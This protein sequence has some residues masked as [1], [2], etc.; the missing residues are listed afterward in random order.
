MLLFVIN[1]IAGGVIVGIAG[2][3]SDGLLG[4]WLAGA[5]ANA[6]IT[7]FIA[8]A[9]TLVYFLLAGGTGSARREPAQETF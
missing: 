2:G 9:T 4:S 1:A 6:L 7:P 5:V 8:I 3:I